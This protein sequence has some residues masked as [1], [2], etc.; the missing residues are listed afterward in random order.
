MF[1][2]FSRN[3]IYYIFLIIILFLFV[4][5]LLYT[6]IIEIKGEHAI[7][8]KDNIILNLLSILIAYFAGIFLPK[9]R[10]IDRINLDKAKKI[11]L[12]ILAIECVIFVMSTALSPGADQLTVLNIA[13]DMHNGKFGAFKHGGY[14]Q[15]YS[16]QLGIILIM[17]VTSAIFGGGNYLSIQL[18][19]CIA[20][21]FLYKSMSKLKDNSA[22]QI[23]ILLAGITFLPIVFYANFVYGTICGLALSVFAIVNAIKFAENKRKIH[24]FLMLISAYFAV[25]VKENYSIFIL[26]ISFYF[27]LLF[28]ESKWYK[29]LLVSLSLIAIIPLQQSITLNIME[30]IVN[31]QIDPPMSKIAWLAMGFQNSSRAEGWY[32]G[33]IES[34]YKKANFDRDAQEMMAK[35]NIKERVSYFKKHKREALKFFRHKTVSQ[36]ND[37]TF[38]SLWINKIRK[39]SIFEQSSFIKKIFSNCGMR[40]TTKYLNFYHLIILFGVLMFLILNSDKKSLEFCLLYMIFI[41][42][43]IFHTFWEAKGQYTLPYFTILLPICV[44]G[45]LSIYNK[46]KLLNGDTI[47]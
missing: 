24:L 37:P 20:V 3:F 5:S 34:S 2:K 30:R 11:L 47:K 6:T 45:Y 43:F 19:N 18:I 33:Y 39:N 15:K 26:G 16:N 9:I 31:Q 40:I 4:N 22:Y 12:I 46:N 23:C 41:G 17:Y 25:M 14:A 27:V 29:F 21:L 7:Y 36:W 38:Q 44:L 13:K 28:F 42:G 8:T 32:N 10:Y 35:E 1:L